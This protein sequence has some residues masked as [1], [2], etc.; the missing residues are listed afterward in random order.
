MTYHSYATSEAHGP[1]K[2]SV[3]GGLRQMSV[4]GSALMLNVT[5]AMRFD[6][7]SLAGLT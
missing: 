3:L 4:P 6:G 7:V 5:M 1:L 2:M